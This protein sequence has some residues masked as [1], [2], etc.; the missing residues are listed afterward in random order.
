MPEG[1]RSSRGE[2]GPAV[3]AIRARSSQALDAADEMLALVRELYPL[4]RSITGDGVR[5]TLDRVAERLPAPLER[6]EVPSGTSVLDWTVPPEWNVR[7]AWIADTSGNRLVDVADSNLHLL[8]YSEPVPRRR[9]ARAELDAHLHSLPDQPQW[10]PYRTSYYERAWGFCLPQRLRDAMTDPEYEVCIDAMLAPGHLSY[11]ELLLP[12]ESEQEILLSAHTCHPAQAN[13]NLASIALAVALA[14]QLHEDGR[15][16]YGVRLLLAPGTIG[17]ITWLARNRERAKRIVGGLTLMGL[18]D[19]APLRYKRTIGGDA[20][21]D[22]AAA[23]V[24]RRSAGELRDFEPYGYDERQYNAPGFRLPVGSLTRGGHA[25]YPEYHTSADTPELLSREQ[26]AAAYEAALAIVEVVQEDRVYT[27]RAPYGEPQLGRR[28]AYRSLAGAAG[29]ASPD[30][31][32]MAMLWVLQL[33]DGAHSLL[34]VAERAELPFE[35]VRAAADL[36]RAH[37]LLEEAP[38]PALAA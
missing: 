30:K 26:L 32:T 10:T 3:P 27:S 25:G 13:D 38:P 11:G 24:L 12:G 21:I 33:A 17:A 18:G 4:P 14:R 20:A 8:G 28:G 19:D 2:P 9:I 34:D 5:A 37:E 15:R 6:H 16:R 36:L 7:E 1:R 29:G 31:L 23:H 35:Q 22:R